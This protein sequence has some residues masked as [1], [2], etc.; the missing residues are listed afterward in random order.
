MPQKLYQKPVKFV[1]MS[2]NLFTILGSGEPAD[3][4]Y[5]DLEIGCRYDVVLETTPNGAIFKLSKLVAKQLNSLD[6]TKQTRMIKQL[7][8]IV[9]VLFFHGA[10]CQT[11]SR[12]EE[13]KA[14]SR[15]IEE[16]LKATNKRDGSVFDTLLIGKRPDFPDVSLPPKV[17]STV[18]LFLTTKETNEKRKRNKNLVFVNLVGTVTNDLSEFLFVTFYPD[19]KHQCDCIV[20]LKFDIPNHTFKLQRVDFKNYAD[21]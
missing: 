3:E 11:V 20:D 14:Y 9:F 7:A 5:V 1:G 15:A 19:Y 18:I 4:V 21:K 6:C 2:S 8:F 16:Y 17:G 12:T 10:F 13:E